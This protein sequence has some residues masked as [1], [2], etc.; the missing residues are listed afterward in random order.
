MGRLVLHHR[1]EWYSA[2]EL[3]LLPED[4]EPDEEMFWT[5]SETPVWEELESIPQIAEVLQSLTEPGQTFTFQGEE[6]INK[7][8]Q[9]A[10]LDDGNFMLELAV[11]DDGGLQHAHRIW[12]GC[13]PDDQPSG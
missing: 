9:G 8:A 6:P 4:P 5:T 7:Y 12:S 11:V 10:R 1:R 3:N 2:E 13:G